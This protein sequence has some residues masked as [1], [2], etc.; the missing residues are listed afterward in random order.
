MT[1]SRRCAL[2]AG[3]RIYDLK[4]V[5]VTNRVN[6]QL[7]IKNVFQKSI[8]DTFLDWLPGDLRII[9]APSA[10]LLK[11]RCSPFLSD[12]QDFHPAFSFTFIDVENAEAFDELR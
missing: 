4:S 9:V 11:L 10:G 2:T 7:F 8:L 5:C 3:H 12:E 6:I 1:Y